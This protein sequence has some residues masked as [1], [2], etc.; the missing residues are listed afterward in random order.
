[1][2]DPKLIRR[3]KLGPSHL[4]TGKTHHYHGTQQLPPPSELR[5]V[6]Y[7][8]DP[9]FYLFYCDDTGKEFTDTYHETLEEALSQAAWEFTVRP[10]EWAAGE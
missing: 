4:P 3:V 6:Q 10:D 2:N 5:I 9:G 1:M 7:A 8:D